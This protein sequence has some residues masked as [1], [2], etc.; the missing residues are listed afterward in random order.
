MTPCLVTASQNTQSQLGIA[1]TLQRTM[2]A[3]VSAT[4]NTQSLFVFVNTRLVHTFVVRGTNTEHN[5][6]GQN[7]QGERA[8]E[9]G[10]Y[11]WRRVIQGVNSQLEDN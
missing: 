1:V 5:Y 6:G 3:M 11:S 10:A 4:T 8:D 2:L 7:L 9:E